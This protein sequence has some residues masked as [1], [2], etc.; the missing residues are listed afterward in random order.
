M[1]GLGF[2][3]AEKWRQTRGRLS[4]VIHFCPQNVQILEAWVQIRFFPPK[5]GRVQSEF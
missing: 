1:P 4:F 3:A 5:A 2:G